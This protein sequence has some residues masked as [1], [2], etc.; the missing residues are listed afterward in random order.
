MFLII[1]RISHYSGLDVLV[2]LFH[3]QAAATHAREVYLETLRRNGDPWA[4]QLYTKVAP[5]QD[6]IIVEVQTALAARPGTEVFVV[7][8]V[9][10]SFGQ[11]WRTL[12]G[13]AST[14]IEAVAMVRVPFVPREGTSGAWP[15]IER[16]TIDELVEE[17]V[18]GMA[19]PLLGRP[20]VGLNEAGSATWFGNLDGLYG[21]AEPVFNEVAAELAHIAPG[22]TQPARLWLDVVDGVV[23]AAW[24]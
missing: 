11:N 1:R 6:T 2:G 18:D 5:E 9:E 10:E 15:I 13:Y 16:L 17:Q 23:V 8:R 14:A 7:S 24:A 21:N 12:V 22:T 3:D 4:E 20:F 19:R